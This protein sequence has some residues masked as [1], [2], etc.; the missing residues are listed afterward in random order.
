MDET[1]KRLA[2][3]LPGELKGHLLSV[4]NSLASR[5][6]EIRL[7]SGRP[8]AVYVGAR[9]FFVRGRSG[10]ALTT[11]GAQIRAAVQRLCDYSLYCRE[12]DLAKGFVTVKGGHR[13]GICATMNGENEVDLSS[14]GSASI[15]I[16]REVRGCADVIFAAT[17]AIK[18]CSV[19]IAS[20]PQGGKTTML[21]DFART[22]ANAPYLKKTVIVDERGEIA[23]VFAG[24]RSLDTGL[25]SDILDGYP[26]KTAFEIAVRTLSPELIVC[27]ELYSEEDFLMCRHARFSGVNVVASVHAGGPEELMKND[28]ARMA[29]DGGVFDF[30]VFLKGQ[31]RIGELAD[32]AEV[33]R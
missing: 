6:T 13:V 26:R 18:P 16:A 15:R 3:M 24:T 22:A 25:C 1:Y 30:V 11:D 9:P 23:N 8:V 20:E 14:I 5:A 10:R 19:L 2:A 12:G 29:I 32:I 27:D 17:Y 28:F 21:R 33:V 4:D 31:S 7:R